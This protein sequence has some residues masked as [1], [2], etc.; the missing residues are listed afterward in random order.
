MN[1]VDR[2][3]LREFREESMERLERISRCLTLMAG[4]GLP[5]PELL[6]DLFR[7]THSLKGGAN[8][9]HLKPVEEL[10]HKLEDILAGIRSGSDAADPEL[11]GILGAGFIRISALL[12]NLHVLPFVDASRDLA[13]IDRRLDAR[14]KK[15]RMRN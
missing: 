9:L 14:Q 10:C 7:E 6:H 13:D 1:A 2:E 4:S 3:A 8:L 12:E 11:I 5:D 15:L